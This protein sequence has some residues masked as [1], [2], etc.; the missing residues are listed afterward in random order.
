MKNREKITWATYPILSLPRRCPSRPLLLGSPLF[1]W[2]FSTFFKI[3]RR[4]NSLLIF[5]L[6][7]LDDVPQLCQSIIQV[8]NRKCELQGKKNSINLQKMGG[9]L[10]F[11]WTR[12][13]GQLWVEVESGESGGSSNSSF[14]EAVAKSKRNSSVAIFWKN[15]WLPIQFSTINNCSFL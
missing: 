14:T 3:I 13:R 1:S 10:A 11:C 6:L 8:G 7:I 9:L 4:K 15:K 12:S 2:N 5:I